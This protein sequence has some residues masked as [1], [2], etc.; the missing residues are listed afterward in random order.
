MADPLTYIC[1]FCGRV[2]RVGR[3]CPGCAGKR[4]QGKRPA[5]KSWEQ[6]AAAD[7][8]DL[9]DEEFD[10]DDFVSREFGHAPHR[11]IGVK[12]YWWLLGLIA[13]GAMAAAIIGPR[14]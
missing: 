13:L 10:Y 7:G 14:F 2:A 3:P 6:E 12:W 8:L 9:P 4:K 1:P 5:K 11:R